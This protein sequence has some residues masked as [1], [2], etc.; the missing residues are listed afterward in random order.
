MQSKDQRGR[1][2]LG[3]EYIIIYIY[4]WVI[5]I[6]IVIYLSEQIMLKEE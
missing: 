2:K 1:R 4:N 6:Y 3:R 5:V